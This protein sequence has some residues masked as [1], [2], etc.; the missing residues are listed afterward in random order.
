MWRKSPTQT[1]LDWES[2]LIPWKIDSAV[3]MRKYLASTRTKRIYSEAQQSYPISLCFVPITKRIKGLAKTRSITQFN[4]VRP[5]D[6]HFFNL[7]LFYCCL[8]MVT[9]YTSNHID[10]INCHNINLA[11]VLPLL[12]LTLE[13]GQNRYKNELWLCWRHKF[14]C[15]IWWAAVAYT[16]IG[17]V[18]DIVTKFYVRTRWE[19]DRKRNRGW[20]ERWGEMKWFPMAEFLINVFRSQ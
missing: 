5:S 6:F 15:S 1:A 9:I 2:Y 7:L 10:E 17:Y 12:L 4:I 13:D 16:N 11:F 20:R 14:L 8:S 3:T 19:E 18:Y